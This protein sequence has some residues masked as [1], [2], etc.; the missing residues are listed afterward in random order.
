MCASAGDVTRSGVLH[1]PLLVASVV[2]A[3]RDDPRSVLTVRPLN[4][5][6]LVRIVPVDDAVALEHPLLARIISERL[7]HCTV[8]LTSRLERVVVERGA[9]A[10]LLVVVPQLVGTAVVLARPHDDLRAR[11]GAPAPDVQHLTVQLTDDVKHLSL[12]TGRGVAS[13]WWVAA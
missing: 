8:S 9:D 6:H 4:V 5:Q 12:S 11:A 1:A 10:A 2:R 3:P 7:H 13:G